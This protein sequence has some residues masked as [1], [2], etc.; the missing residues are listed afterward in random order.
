MPYCQ[1]FCCKKDCKELEWDTFKVDLKRIYPTSRDLGH[2]NMT[3]DIEILAGLISHCAHATVDSLLTHTCRE[4]LKGM[5]YKRVWGVRETG[6]C[7]DNMR[8]T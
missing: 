1:E 3:N 5:G 8:P 4:R 7:R 6:Y 2:S